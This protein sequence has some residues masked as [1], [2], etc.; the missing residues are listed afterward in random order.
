MIEDFG[1]ARVLITG[2]ADGIGFA[3]AQ[4]LQAAGARVF[5]SDI[6][7][8]K[9]KERAGELGAPSAPCD[10]SDA[11]AVEELVERAESEIGPLSLLCA[12]AGVMVPGSILDARQEDVD[13]V[14]GVN[15][16]GVVNACRPF[17]RRLRAAGRGGALLLTGSEHSLANPGYLRSVPLH[18]YN[19]S[20]HA[21]LSIGDSLRAELAADDISVSVLCPGPVVSGLATNS[22]AFR[23]SRFGKTPAG[24]ELDLS[25]VDTER[26]GQLYVPASRAAEIAL[27]GLRAGH[28]V[29]PTHAF[30]QADVD[31]RHRDV[32]AGFA[33]LG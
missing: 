12:N 24:V 33:L 20:K 32:T 7:A 29:I 9:L 5:L 6:A 3:L 13:F 10:V 17:V 31:E 18:V 25:G 21:V 28:F 8:E 4:A 2:A 16:W 26:L 1:D 23:P 30:Q 11:A 19:L 15:V 27:A 14:M 22:D